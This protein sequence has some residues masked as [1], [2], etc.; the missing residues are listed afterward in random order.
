MLDQQTAKGYID[1]QLKEAIKETL[2]LENLRQ[3]HG[4]YYS[5]DRDKRWDRVKNLIMRWVEW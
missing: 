5:M 3:S 1:D 2:V 4:R